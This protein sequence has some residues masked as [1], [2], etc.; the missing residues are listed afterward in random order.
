[1]ASIPPIRLFIRSN[2]DHFRFFAY[3]VVFFILGQAVNFLLFPLTDAVQF[4]VLNAQV[5]S[6]IINTVNPSENTV[7]EDRVIRSGRHAVEVGWGCEATDGMITLGAGVLA[8]RIPVLMKALGLV[9]GSLLIYVA[10]LCRIVGLYFIYKY[11]PRFFDFFHIYVGQ[12]FLIV[13]AISFFILWARYFH[14]IPGTTATQG[15]N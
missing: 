7:V 14:G 8:L 4:K 3:F 15:Q 2:K 5:A 10:N 12:V 1:M 6:N 11:G 9:L 13:I